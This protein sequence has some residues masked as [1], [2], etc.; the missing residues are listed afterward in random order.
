MISRSVRAESLT[1][2][3]S[4]STKL[5]ASRSHSRFSP[6]QILMDSS[7]A[8]PVPLRRTTLAGALTV[9]GDFY[10]SG[11]GSVVTLPMSF[12][13]GTAFTL[14]WGLGAI[15]Y[16]VC[17]PGPGFPGCLLGSADYSHTATPGFDVFNSA[18]QPIYDAT[19]VA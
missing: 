12:H 11:D 7:G 13:Y 2:W 3:P 5:S 9:G 17:T 15:T 8:S 6:S 4:R 18:S 10:V 14:T 1:I 19:V 16:P